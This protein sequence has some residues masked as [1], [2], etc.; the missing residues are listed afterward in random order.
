MDTAGARRLNY[1][2]PSGLNSRARRTDFY[3]GLLAEHTPHLAP[4]VLEDGAQV[5]EDPA[6]RGRPRERPA[7]QVEQYDVADPRGVALGPERVRVEPGPEG[8]AHLAVDE[9]P[10]RVPFVDAGPPADRQAVEAQ[11]IVDARPAASGS[12]EMCRKRKCRKAGV[13]RSRLR[14]VA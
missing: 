8:A 13:R 2:S 4:P 12:D 14:A 9:A 7:V 6:E 10:W 1:S 5:G 11:R 3:L